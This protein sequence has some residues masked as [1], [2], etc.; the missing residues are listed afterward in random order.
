MNTRTL[1]DTDFQKINT[2]TLQKEVEK[3]SARSWTTKQV[4]MIVVIVAFTLAG[5]ISYAQ[6]PGLGGN[7]QSGA[8]GGDVNAYGKSVTDAATKGLTARICYLDAQAKLAEALQNKTEAYVKLSES[9][10]AVEGATASKK[11]EAMK[12]TTVTPDA[13]KE[14][15]DALAESKELLLNQRRNFR[16]AAAN[17]SSASLRNRNWPSK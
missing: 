8:G 9:L 10:R 16:K 7:K 6:F 5:R 1:L 14:M 2:T 3:M 15:E 17:L 13:K 11:V 12:N 4:G